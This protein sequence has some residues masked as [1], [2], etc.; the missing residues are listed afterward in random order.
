M[1][2]YPV[3]SQNGSRGNLKKAMKYLWA[4]N[5]RR[6]QHFDEIILLR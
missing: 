4:I 6:D 3:T 5:S 1:S 2:D